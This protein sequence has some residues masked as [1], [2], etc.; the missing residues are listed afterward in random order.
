MLKCVV[1][2][3]KEI[4]RLTNKEIASKSDISESTV[5]RIL[6]GKND[7]PTMIEL[8]GLSYCFDVPIDTLAENGS[9]R[10]LRADEFPL[11]MLYRTLPESYKRKAAKAVNDIVIEWRD[12]LS[13]SYNIVERQKFHRYV[14]RMSACDLYD[15]EEWITNNRPHLIDHSISDEESHK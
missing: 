7:N 3:L 8:K 15:I 9:D 2:N 13:S 1:S 5:C 11:M 12:S 14:D 6:N 4:F 10:I